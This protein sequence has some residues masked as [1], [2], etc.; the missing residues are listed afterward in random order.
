[1]NTK[2]KRNKKRYKID[3]TFGQVSRVTVVERGV[4]EFSS[5]VAACS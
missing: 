3:G 5:P 2:K 1:M 4:W